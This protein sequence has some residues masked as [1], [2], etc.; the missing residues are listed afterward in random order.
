MLQEMAQAWRNLA[1]EE[2]RKKAAVFWLE[3]GHMPPVFQVDFGL[4]EEE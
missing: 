2:E 3:T 1:D 4:R